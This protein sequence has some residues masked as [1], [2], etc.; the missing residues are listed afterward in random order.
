MGTELEPEGGLARGRLAAVGES[1][2]GTVGLRSL[3]SRSRSS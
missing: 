2:E 1:A 3:A